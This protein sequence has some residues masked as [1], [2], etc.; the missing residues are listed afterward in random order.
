MPS[1]QSA[2]IKLSP[3]QH[4]LFWSGVFIAFMLFVWVFKAALLPFVLGFAIA[5][6]LDPVMEKLSGKAIP[7][8][9]SRCHCYA[10]YKGCQNQGAVRSVLNVLVVRQDAGVAPNR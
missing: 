5:Y 4:A 3:V 7:R 8:W 10:L 2:A 1:N 6:L 9:A